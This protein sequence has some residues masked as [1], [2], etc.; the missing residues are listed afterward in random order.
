[1]STR[2]TCLALKQDTAAVFTNR[3]TDGTSWLTRGGCAKWK[4][5]RALVF[6]PGWFTVHRGWSVTSGIDYLN[7]G[8]TD[9][10]ASILTCR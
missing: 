4:I 1:M 9:R 3:R 7:S 8:V 2:P 5:V 10:Q 6:K